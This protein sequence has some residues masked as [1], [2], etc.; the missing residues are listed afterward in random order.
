[1]YELFSTLGHGDVMRDLSLAHLT[2][3]HAS[4]PD[5]LAMAGRCGYRYVGLRLTE[6]TGGDAWPLIGDRKLMKATRAEM[7]ASG[8]G[9]LDVELARLRPE[10]RV[11]EFEPMLEAAAELNARHVLTQGHDSDKHRL[12]DNYAAF[13]DLAAGHGLTADIEFLTWTDLCGVSEARALIEAAGRPNAGLMIDTLHFNRSR[14]RLEEL[15]AIPPGWFHY[16][17]I[18][19]AAGPIPETTEALIHTAREDR[20]LPGEGGIDLRGIIAR[21]PA[22][23]PIAV[24]IPNSRMAE[25]MSDEERARRAYEATRALLAA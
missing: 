3:L 14:C 16:I 12:T 17:Q 20:L 19:D 1:M 4:P 21:L 11:E 22:D 10:T 8:V 18:A 5:L 24:E 2:V 7:A 13:C 25:T 6:V 15:D 9:V 23:I